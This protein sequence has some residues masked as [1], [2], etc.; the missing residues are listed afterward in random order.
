MIDRF[1]IADALEACDWSGSPIGNKE[2]LKAATRFLREV[3]A[4]PP[5]PKAPQPIEAVLAACR[6]HTPQFDRL[7]AD[8]QK[9]AIDM[10]TAAIHAYQQ[11]VASEADQRP[12]N[13][14]HRLQD[15]GKSYPRSSCAGC[16]KNIITG[17]GRTCQFAAPP[18]KSGSIN[19]NS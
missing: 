9:Y 7:D 17:L 14:R 1:R 3:D 16:G 10:M 8:I 4:A 5:A 2:I 11:A 12:A 13:C 18:L 15:E 6:A 19:A